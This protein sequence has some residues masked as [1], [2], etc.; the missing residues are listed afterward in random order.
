MPLSTRRNCGWQGQAAK[1]Q[2]VTEHCRNLTIN[3]TYR[4]D[5][6]WRQ[7]PTTNKTT[8]PFHTLL[9]SGLTDYEYWEAIS[10]G[11]LTPFWQIAVP[12][13]CALRGR[14]LF[15]WL[16]GFIV[17]VDYI[18]Y[19]MSWTTSTWILYMVFLSGFSLGCRCSG[20]DLR[21][22]CK[23]SSVSLTQNTSFP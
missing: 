2:S 19:R 8:Q 5:V 18:L 9:E 14:Y 6:L 1:V 3:R 21:F 15:F 11:F 12:G 17:R 13:R 10:R 4:K 23:A 22:I 16:L 20:L 7:V